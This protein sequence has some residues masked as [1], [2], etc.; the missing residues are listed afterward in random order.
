MRPFITSLIFLAAGGLFVTNCEVP[1]V[2]KAKFDNVQMLVDD[3]KTRITEIN[4]EDL[5]AMMEEGEYYILVDVRTNEEHDAGYIPG[6]VSIPRG[7]LEFR[8]A[9]TTFWDDEGMY[10]PEPYDMLVVYCRSGGRSA[11]AADILQRMG[12]SNVISLEG[13][14]TKWKEAFPEKVEKNLAPVTNPIPTE[15]ITAEADSDSC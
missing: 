7:R 14:F 4:S 1:C 10:L 12:Y 8:I 5:Q 2:Y 15:G 6:S 13:G 9:S 3:A 11:L